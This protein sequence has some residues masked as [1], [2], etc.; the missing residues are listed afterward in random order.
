MTYV[1]V[2]R[3]KRTEVLTEIENLRSTASEIAN[4]LAAKEGQLRNL[5]D[6]LALEAESQGSPA[7]PDSG[8]PRGAPLK[9]QRFTDAAVSVLADNGAPIHYQDLARMLS[10]RGVYVPGK[11]P[12]ANLIAHMLRDE[13]F[14]RGSGRGMYGLSEWPGMKRSTPPST[15]GRRMRAAR[16]PTRRVLSSE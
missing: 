6:L 13:R 16:R 12:G 1:D 15:R 14:S 10:D 7:D 4:K 2:L 5:D 8:Q 9:S 11:D 3:S